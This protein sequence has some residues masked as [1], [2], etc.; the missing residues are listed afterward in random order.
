MAEGSSKKRIFQIAKELNISHKD[1]IEYLCEEGI[2]V[3]SPN[4][5]IEFELYEKI[6][7]E[8]SKEK[9]SI[10]RFRKEQARKAV[11]D[12]RR[13]TDIKRDD[14]TG[15]QDPEDVKQA[16]ENAIKREQ[17][18][19]SQ[20]QS[21]KDSI[22]KEQDRLET[23]RAADEAKR[24]AEEKERFVQEETR[25]KELEEQAAKEQKAKTEEEPELKGSKLKIISRP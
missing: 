23:L 2:S 13:K 24:E 10:D 7:G 21:L 3:S 16:R 6:L 1:I 14:K 18:K 5:P 20:Y 9:M 22:S 4:A 15:S 17:E 19:E 11:V 25:R 12:T 8:F